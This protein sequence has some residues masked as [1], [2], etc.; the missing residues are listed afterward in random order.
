MG[1]VLGTEKG[2][3]VCDLLRQLCQLTPLTPNIRFGFTAF[4]PKPC[5][6]FVGATRC[7]K[8]ESPHRPVGI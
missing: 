8:L 7:E 6:L 2:V 3:C 1:A 4:N 5:D